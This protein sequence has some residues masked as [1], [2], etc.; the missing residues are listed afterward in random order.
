METYFIKVTTIGMMPKNTHIKVSLFLFTI[1]IIIISLILFCISYLPFEIVKSKLNTFAPDGSAESFIPEYFDKIKIRLQ[2][3]GIVMLI[4]SGLFYTNIRRIQK[5]ISNIPTS[6]FS[7]LREVALSF[8]KAVK[9]EDKIHL[10]TLFLILLLTIVVRSIYL[11]QPMRYDEAFTFT[12]YAS[13]PLFLGLSNYSFPNNHLFH[14]LL[15]HMACLV[16]GNQ[17]WVIRLPALFAGVLLAPVSYLV[18]RTFYNKH[19]ALLTTSLV[20]SSSALIGYS[21]NA[22][23]YTLICLFFLLLLLLGT[24]LKQCRNSVAWLLFSITSAL[25]FYTIPIML[26]PFGIVITWLL[27]S[28]VLKD[29]DVDRGL[30]FKDVFIYLF[31][32][33]F[34][35]FTLYIPVFVRSGFESV[36]ANR[37][38][39]PISWSHFVA[40]FPSALIS[41]WNQ[42][43]KDIP[44]GIRFLFIIGFFTSLFVHKRLTKHHVPL[45]LSVVIFLL[46]ILALQRVIPFTRVW[47]FLLPLY[48]GLSSAGVSYLLE[49]VKSNCG[50]Y[51]SITFAALALTLSFWM[52]LNLIHTNSV[53]YSNETGTLRDAERITIFMR[54]YLKDGD[55]VLAVCPSNAPLKYYFNK[56]YISD[57]YLIKD[58]KSSNRI[59][60]IVNEPKQTI[61]EVLGSVGLT[62]NNYIIPKLIQRYKFAT[63]YEVNMGDE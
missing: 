24:Y 62:I 63:L 6:F 13:K 26:Y 11:F 23:G 22:R 28:S 45:A 49:L 43:N 54:Q 46:P 36:I 47:L 7:L 32:I 33:A 50:N 20:A 17:P 41:V 5:Y 51:K 30:L 14:T 53:Y 8:N 16:F 21:T 1:F 61:E 58:V 31:I 59:L 37:T 34:L 55:R 60:V 3:T 10:Y 44:T 57:N 29:T 15:V 52:S 38:V 25:G 27:L 18:I 48:I 35:T 9:N 2:F 19:A 39:A 12:N 40:Q 42:W 4:A 56:Y